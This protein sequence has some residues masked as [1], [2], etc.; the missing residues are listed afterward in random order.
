M[1][2]LFWAFI[3]LIL[4]CTSPA[5]VGETEKQF[6]TKN[7]IKK[8]FACDTTGVKPSILYEKKGDSL[9]LSNSF[10][11]LKNGDS[12]FIFHSYTRNETDIDVFKKHQIKF[13]ILCSKNGDTL[14]CYGKYKDEAFSNY[15]TRIHDTTIYGIVIGK[16]QID[17]I[18]YIFKKGVCINVDTIY[19][20]IDMRYL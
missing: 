4:G 18:N 17:R 11:T 13:S 1:N 14:F 7:R 2:K 9:I 8:N 3:I 10:Y 19:L 15:I 16:K 12:V 6:C 5:Y 20:R